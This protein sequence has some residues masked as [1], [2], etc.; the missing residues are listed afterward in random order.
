MG[1]KLV[2]V[3]HLKMEVKRWNCLMFFLLTVY[4]SHVTR[5]Q[6]RKISN[7]DHIYGIC[8]YLQLPEAMCCC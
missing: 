2:G 4:Q 7:A 5:R 8:V 3:L 1:L 6:A